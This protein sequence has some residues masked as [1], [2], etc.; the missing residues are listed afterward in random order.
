MHTTPEIVDVLA[1]DGD[2]LQTVTLEGL[3]EFVALEVLRRMTGNRDIVVVKQQLHVQVLGDSETSGFR[4]V[5]L[6]LRTVRGPT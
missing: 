5:A 6:L 1:V 2:D 4:V 3:G